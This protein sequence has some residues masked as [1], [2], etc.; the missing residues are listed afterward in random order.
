MPGMEDLRRKRLPVHFLLSEE[1]RY[2]A[3][4]QSF[5]AKHMGVSFVKRNVT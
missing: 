1:P 4:Q 2:L 5:D 3:A